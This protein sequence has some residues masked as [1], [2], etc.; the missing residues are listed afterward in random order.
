MDVGHLGQPPEEYDKSMM[1]DY[2]RCR[3]A[4]LL[5]TLLIAYHA[6]PLL[7]KVASVDHVDA[8]HMKFIV[9]F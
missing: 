5:I 3:G 9:L 1:V 6:H 8:Y 4:R 7:I 2:G